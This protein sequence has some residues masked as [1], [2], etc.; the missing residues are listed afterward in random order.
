ME[1]KVLIL[2]VIGSGHWVSRVGQIPPNPYTAVL[3]PEKTLQGFS[4]AKDREWENEKVSFRVCG[5]KN[6][7]RQS[8]T[9]RKEKDAE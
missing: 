4:W 9:V 3:K 1:R 8:Q 6:W 7:Q 2:F 5:K